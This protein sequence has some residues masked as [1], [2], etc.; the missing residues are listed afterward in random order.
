[1]KL[2]EIEKLCN[3]A[4]PGPW[5]GDYIPLQAIRILDYS[6]NMSKNI[7][8]I[9]AA[10]MLMP[11]LLKVAKAANLFI[12]IENDPDLYLLEE[13]SFEAQEALQKSLEEL[14][15]DERI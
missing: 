5:L 11:K 4:T 13:K 3:E 10:R 15:I 12:E 1:M 6:D 7:E 2:D 14:E 9:A 8:F